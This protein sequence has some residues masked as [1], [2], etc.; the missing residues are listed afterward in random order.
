MTR[1]SLDDTVKRRDLFASPGGLPR[2]STQGKSNLKLIYAK[3]F[4]RV[5][6]AILSLVEKASG[7][8]GARLCLGTDVRKRSL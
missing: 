7:G 4:G 6:C 3:L 1:L 2:Q 5:D 8:V